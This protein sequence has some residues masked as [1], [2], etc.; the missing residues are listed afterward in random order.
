M[1]NKTNFEVW[2]ERY[3]QSGEVIYKLEDNGKKILYKTYKQRLIGNNFYPTDI[4]Y[5][6]WCGDNWKSFTDYRT[7][8][9]E[10]KRK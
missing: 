7:A 4:F 2:V 5:H 3:K 6:V 9:A 8:L 1:A 10:F